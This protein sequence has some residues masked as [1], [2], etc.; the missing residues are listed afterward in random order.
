MFR[1]AFL[2]FFFSVSSVLAAAKPVY[3]L[4]L[5][6]TL[7][8]KHMTSQGV[9]ATNLQKSEIQQKSENGTESFI[10]V[11]PQA[12]VDE[13]GKVHLKFS[14]G[15]IVKGERRILSMPEMI[16]SEGKQATITIGEDDGPESLTLSV[17]AHRQLQK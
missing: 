7:N 6:L 1:S 15:L 8:G 17:L 4:A 14:I 5:D 13:P 11:T 3:K 12:L 16:V 10:E 2:I 9:M